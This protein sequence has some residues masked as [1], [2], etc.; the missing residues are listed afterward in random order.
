MRI[1]ECIHSLKPGGAERLMVDLSNELSGTDEVVVL[2]LWNRPERN[3]G[4]YLPELSKNIRFISLNLSEGFHPSYLLKIY[5][6]IRELRPDIVHVHCIV[7]Y[8][9]LP[10]L[11]YRKCR[12]VQTLH[13]EAEHD[14]IPYFWSTWKWLLRRRLLRLVTI[15][16][17]NRMSFRNRSRLDCD[18]LIYNGR[19]QP[20]KSGK[21]EAVASFVASLKNRPDD[22]LLLSVGRSSPQK[23]IG[24]MVEA[25]NELADN[26]APIQLILIGDHGSTEHGRR[27]MEAAGPAVHFVGVKDN[28]ADYFLSCDAFCLSSLYEGMPITLI[29]AFACRCVPVCT[30]CSGVADAVENGLTGFVSPSFSK[31]DYKRSILDYLRNKERIDKDDLYA[32]YRSMF[33]IGACASQYRRLFL[34]LSRSTSHHKKNHT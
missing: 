5:R 24:M 7:H 10:I 15:S 31:D 30:P 1:V 21:F 27:W 4:F 20:E 8:F 34:S 13:N 14:V 9:I 28:V 25:V 29:E 12:Y 33:S 6:T 32:R 3:E 19:K 16:R 23:N 18:T 2:A 17:S 22:T 11:L 26:G